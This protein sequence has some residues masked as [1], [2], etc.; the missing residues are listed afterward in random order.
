MTKKL[1]WSISRIHSC[2]FLAVYIPVNDSLKAQH[3]D[4]TGSSVRQKFSDKKSWRCKL[5]HPSCSS[6]STFPTGVEKVSAFQLRL[7]WRIRISL[8]EV[9]KGCAHAVAA[10]QPCALWELTAWCSVMLAGVSRSCVKPQWQMKLTLFIFFYPVNKESAVK[11][12]SP[13]CRGSGTV[14]FKYCDK[15]K[16]HLGRLGSR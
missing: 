1:S 15:S 5:F 9:L 7:V 13:A 10:N 6:V 11:S 14:C 4:L 2:F 16:Q 3:G 12:K 8:T